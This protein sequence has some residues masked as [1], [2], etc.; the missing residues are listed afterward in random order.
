MYA[1]PVVNMS[2][3]ASRQKAKESRLKMVQ[4]QYMTERSGLDAIRE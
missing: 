2:E 4:S 3:V 1:L